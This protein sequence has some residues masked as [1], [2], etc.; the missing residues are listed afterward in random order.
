MLLALSTAA[1]IYYPGVQEIFESD[2]VINW[3]AFGPHGQYVV[4]TQKSLHHTDDDVVRQYDNGGVVPLRCASFGYEGA[5]VCV[6]DDG[7]IRSSGLSAKVKA[8]LD[9]K[10]VRN[11]QLSAHSSATFFV[12]YMDG[13]TTWSMPS[14]WLSDIQPVRLDDPGAPGEQSVSQRIIFAFGHKI[15]IFC[16][17]NGKQA[18]WYVDLACNRAFLERNIRRGID[19]SYATARLK[20]KGTMEAFSLGENGAW[21]WRG[22]GSSS[23]TV[24]FRPK[25]HY[26]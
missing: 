20:R 3:V 9:K 11:I 4:D 13:D 18:R 16:I 21:F 7:V 5:W 22:D 1:A 14:T 25:V 26:F 24:D 8:A 12:E 19:D 17:S 23:C 6:E 15:G 10:A 2:D